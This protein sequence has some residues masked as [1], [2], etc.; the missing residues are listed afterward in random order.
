M[1]STTNTALTSSG[2]GIDSPDG[3]QSIQLQ[4]TYNARYLSIITMLA[5][6]S[7]WFLG[8]NRA[9]MCNR[10]EGKWI[11]HAVWWPNLYDAGTLPTFAA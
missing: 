3:Q 9:N 2:S 7:D 1:L 10:R 6:S 11:K 8:V 5:P 4:T